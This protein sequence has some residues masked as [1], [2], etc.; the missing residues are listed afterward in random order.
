MTLLLWTLVVPAVTAALGVLP[1][2]R[3]VKEARLVAGLCVTL[4][5]SAATAGKF[6]G[7]SVPTVHFGWRQERVAETASQARRALVGGLFG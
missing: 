2:P 7:G 1:G 3:W 4:I 5:L 6:L